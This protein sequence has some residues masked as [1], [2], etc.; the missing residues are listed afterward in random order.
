[1]LLAGIQKGTEE[2]G[3]GVGRGG[4]SH[5]SHLTYRQP[6]ASNKKINIYRCVVSIMKRRKG[7]KGEA[8]GGMRQW[9]FYFI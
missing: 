3:G 6:G 4:D 5:C 7:K 8:N 2:G 9:G 1:M